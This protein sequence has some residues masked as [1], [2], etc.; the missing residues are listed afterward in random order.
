MKLF[1]INRNLFKLL[2]LMTGILFF[3]AS[4][5]AK[6]GDDY[7]AEKA[8]AYA[9]SCFTLQ[10]GKYIPNPSK[11]YGRELCAGYVSQCLREGGM[12]E[13]ASWY[14]KGIGKTPD[15][16]RLSNTLYNYL[17]NCGYEIIDSPNESEINEGDVI[18]YYTGSSW[19]HCA[20]CV[21]KNSEGTP[22][23]NAYN[24]PH[25]HYSNWRLYY[26]KVCVVS[27]G[28]RTQSPE[29]EESALE[30]GKEITLSCATSDS[31]I[32]Y[33]T[34]GKNPTKKSTVYKKP[35]TLK[36]SSEVRAFASSKS[37]SNSKITSSYIN[38]E[39]VLPNGDYVILPSSDHSKALGIS[40]SSK[41]ENAEIKLAK[42]TEHYNQK[43]SLSYIKNG[44]YTVTFL[45]SGLVLTEDIQTTD[46][47]NEEAADGDSSDA[48]VVPVKK[49]SNAKVTQVTYSICQKKATGKKNQQWKL[50]CTGKNRFT[51][52][53]ADTSHFLSLDKTLSTGEKVYP[54]EQ[55]IKQ[56]Q[57]FTLTPTLKSQ[58]KLIEEKFPEKITLGSP[59]VIYGNLV[60]NYNLTSVTITIK[61]N[62]K[63][64]AASASGTP[65]A[66]EYDLLALSPKIKFGKL[67]VGTYSF[68]VKAK[69]ETGQTT[70]LA[71]KSF[72]VC[73]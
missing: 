11:K 68:I 37:K 58:I 32:Y 64:T 38:T 33:T 31:T 53:N 23:I 72:K 3:S 13:D 21:G 66:Q 10:N 73:K 40:A 56:V 60:S 46:K 34:N 12:S 5:E 44:L 61:D 50:T 29:I 70:T 62:A 18:F 20:I 39:Q 17:K 22:L 59:F 9:D 67:S 6:P 49:I 24:N 48:K 65:D 43:I 57:E 26:N 15:A 30:N 41:K 42:K 16:W 45:H 1:S 27:M 25:C 2:F 7:S 69:D 35:F 54:A 8:I 52:Q 14:W 63:K 71:N 4:A 51:L 19:G 47:N 36:K 28:S 55:N